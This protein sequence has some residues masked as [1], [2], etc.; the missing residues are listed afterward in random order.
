MSRD[1]DK[2]RKRAFVVAHYDEGGRIARHLCNLL[3]ALTTL[4]E[5]VILVSTHV[6]P[7]A[8]ASLPPG[9]RALTR[10]NVGYDFE[11]Y[12]V[13]IDTVGIDAD[14]DQ[15]VLLNSSFVCIDPAKLCH[16]LFDGPPPQVDL[17]GITSSNAGAYHLQSYF[18]SFEGK[19]ILASDAF[20]SWWANLEPLSS[21]DDVINRYEL[22]MTAHFVERGFRAGAAF[23]PDRQQLF[24]AVC[25]WFEARGREPPIGADGRVTIELAGADLLNPMHFLWDDVLD[26]FG[27]VKLELLKTN[28]FG[29]N[30]HRF[31]LL[32]RSDPVVR[33][34]VGDALKAPRAA[35]TAGERAQDPAAARTP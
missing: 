4:S 18:V 9:V 5:T 21:R 10:P 35:V 3:A 23:V 1:G 15:L 28:P 22:G 33:Q 14:L 17:A 13:G 19:A 16:R 11:S 7:Q 26:E 8:L 6:T 24:R 30:L 25:R 34:L 31:A 29:V 27:I 12:R 20:R 32:Q 2:A